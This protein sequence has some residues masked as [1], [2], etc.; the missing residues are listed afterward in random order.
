MPRRTVLSTEQR[1]VLTQLPTEPSVLTRYYQLKVNELRLIRKRRRAK[2]RIGFAIQLCIL[3]YP[4]RALRP[5]ERVPDEL[6]A[7]VAEQIDECPAEFMGYS[8]R[9]ETRREHLAILIKHL[10]LESFTLR[11]YRASLKWLIPLAIEEPKGIFLMGALM[12]E[13]RY[14]KVVQPPIRVMERLVATAQIQTEKKVYQKVSQA[15]HESTIN[16]LDQWL[17]VKEEE[18]VSRFAWVRQPVGKPS[19]ANMLQIFARLKAIEVLKLPHNGVRKLSALRYDMLVR[20]GK[21]VAVHNLRVCKL[22]CV[23]GQNQ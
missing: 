1:I 4:G 17:E 8:E 10:G 21:R 18:R 22:F 16:L 11:H 14:R 12:D 20:E 19:A 13:L 9:E 15:L 2:N 5:G 7:F 23:S 6:V 3:L